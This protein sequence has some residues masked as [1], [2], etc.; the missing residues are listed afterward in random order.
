VPRVVISV[1]NAILGSSENSSTSLLKG[2]LEKFNGSQVDQLFKEIGIPEV[3][4]STPET[5]EWTLRSLILWRG[6]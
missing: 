5:I 2:Y 1:P 4:G 6:K 3:A